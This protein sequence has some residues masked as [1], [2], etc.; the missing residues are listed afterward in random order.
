MREYTVILEP[1]DEGRGYTVL[2][3]A[4][5]GCITQGRTQE[6][7][8]MRAREAI[9]VYIESLEADGEPVPEEREPIQVLKVAV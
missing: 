1:D 9:A 8:L 5:P 4:L 3:P 6:E 7:A 2:V